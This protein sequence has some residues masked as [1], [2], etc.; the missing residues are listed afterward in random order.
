MT[1]VPKRS[2]LRGP[3][4]ATTALPGL[5]P[6]VSDEREAGA[7]ACGSALPPSG[8]Q[9]CD[10][11]QEVVAAHERVLA[12]LTRPSDEGAT[13][14]DW[15]KAVTDEMLAHVAYVQLA[16]EIAY[17]NA[18]DPVGSAKANGAH[19]QDQPASRQGAR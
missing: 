1:S 18:W 10:A 6:L 7:S 17:R 16:K 3:E 13:Y 14:H 8:S 15:L 19:H 11:W 4:V 12:L 9:L 2:P 5:R